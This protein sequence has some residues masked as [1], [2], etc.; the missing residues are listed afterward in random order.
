MSERNT[1][2][3][4]SDQSDHLADLVSLAMIGFALVKQHGAVPEDNPALASFMPLVQDELDQRKV[5]QLEKASL[6]YGIGHDLAIDP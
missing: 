4:S 1:L 6:K 3:L 2:T 5:A